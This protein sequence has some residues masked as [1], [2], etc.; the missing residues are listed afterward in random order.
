MYTSTTIE[1]INTSRETFSTFKVSFCFVELPVMLPS[2]HGNAGIENGPTVAGTR[3]TCPKYSSRTQ[4]AETSGRP[5]NS[6]VLLCVLCG[7]SFTLIPAAVVIF[8]YTVSLPLFVL[9]LNDLSR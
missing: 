7:S 8:L 3:V 2:F 9:L 4:A 1:S 6:S 5:R